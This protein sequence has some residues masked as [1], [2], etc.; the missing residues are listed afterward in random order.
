MKVE[1]QYEQGE[2]TEV[3]ECLY[4]GRDGKK[5][6]ENTRILKEHRIRIVVNDKYTLHTMCTPQYLAEAVLGRLRTEGI[7]DNTEEIESIRICKDGSKAIV[8]LSDSQWNIERKKEIVP[9]T[10]ANWKEEWV[11]RLADILAEEMPLHK[12]TWGTHSCFLAKKGEVLFAC[13]DIGRHNAIDKVIGHAMLKHISLTECILYSSGRMPSDMAE[14][15]IRAGI[16]VAVCKAVPTV[17][18]V[19][20][21]EKY[22]L[23]LI[24][25]ARPDRFRVY[26]A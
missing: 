24:C 19:K 1:N 18:A 13:E 9:I 17:E 3:Q 20:L 10:P 26:H 22:G 2:L 4:I 14:K 7:V 5:M 25:A 6:Q 16:P 15:V 21:A 11:F 23:T 8:K 12:E